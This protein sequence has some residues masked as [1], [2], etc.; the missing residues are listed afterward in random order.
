MHTE[1]HPAL[2]A[3]AE[4]PAAYRQYARLWLR[5]HVGSPH[6]QCNK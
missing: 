1:Q 3:A 4:G 5:S 2:A 6:F